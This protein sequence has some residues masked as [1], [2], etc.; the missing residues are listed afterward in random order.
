MCG[1]RNLVK[2][3]DKDTCNYIRLN[4]PNA[5]K[6]VDQMKN[7]F[8]L[9]DPWRELHDNNLSRTEAEWQGILYKFTVSDQ[10]FFDTLLT[11]IRGETILYASR[12][13]K[14]LVNLENDLEKEIVDLEKIL[15]S[16]TDKDRDL[17]I[18]NEKKAQLGVIKKRKIGR[19]KD[20]I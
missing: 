6:K 12:K 7:D 10:L 14:R 19:N 3:F 9:V 4:N 15:I 18:L 16:K 13:K 2:D 20:E 8:N 11:I 1:D 5:K 17:V